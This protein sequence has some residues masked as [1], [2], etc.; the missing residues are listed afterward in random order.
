MGG[1]FEIA[2]KIGVKMQGK[3]LDLLP[4]DVLRRSDAPKLSATDIRLEGRHPFRRQLRPTVY[5]TEIVHADGKNNL[6]V[7]EEPQLLETLLLISRSPPDHHRF[8]AGLALVVH[9]VNAGHFA[10]EGRSTRRWP[11]LRSGSGVRNAMAMANDLSVIEP[12][13][14]EVFLEGAGLRFHSHAEPEVVMLR[15]QA[16]PSRAVR[17]E[18]DGDEGAS[19]LAGRKVIVVVPKP[20]TLAPSRP[21]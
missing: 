3:S 15:I 12:N 21:T 2:A 4:A 13:L 1:H 10:S 5:R 18:V 20:S 19:A 17:D 8:A 7:R 9:A 16:G 6:A 14:F 11:P